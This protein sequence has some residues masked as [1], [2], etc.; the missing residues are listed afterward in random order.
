MSSSITVGWHEFPPLAYLSDKGEIQ[1]YF[2]E[3][4]NEVAEI[5]WNNES[6]VYTSKYMTVDDLEFSEHKET[7][8]L[9]YPSIPDS[10]LSEVYFPPSV[11]R[12]LPVTESFGSFLIFKEKWR[13]FNTNIGLVMSYWKFL[14]LLMSAT[15]WAGLFM[16]ILERKKNSE[17]FPLD[18][19]RGVFEGFWW[20]FVAMS[21]VGFGDKYPKGIVVFTANITLELN[22][23]GIRYTHDILY[24]TVAVMTGS[25][26]VGITLAKG[27]RPREFNTL[28]EIFESVEKEETNYALVGHYPAVH[29]LERNLNE[30]SSIRIV[31]SFPHRQ[32]YGIKV[33][34]KLDRC[35]LRN[36]ARRRRKFSSAIR[37]ITVAY[38]E[39][40]LL[41]EDFSVSQY[42]TVS[43]QAL[44]YSTSSWLLIV[45]TIESGKVQ[46]YFV[47]LIDEIAKTCWKNKSVIYSSKYSSIKDMRL[48]VGRD[49][50]L[51][52]YPFLSKSRIPVAG[53]DSY[54]I[55]SIPVIES[56]GGFLFKK[57]HTNFFNENIILI[58]S[59]WK[60]ILLLGSATAWI[61]LLMWFM[62]RRINKEQFPKDALVGI[63]EGI[64]WAFV[65]MST[66]G[67]GDRY[68]KR[69]VSKVVTLFWILISLIM[70]S[71]FTANI[72]FEL[73]FDGALNAP[74]LLF[75]RVSVV[76]DMEE[77]RVCLS[78]G[79]VPIEYNTTEEVL[80]SVSSEKVSY[81]L[82]GQYPAVYILN[83][84]L[85]D[86]TIG[87]V[88]NYEY[89]EI[90]GLKVM[91][92]PDKCLL[93][94]IASRKK[95]YSL[96]NNISEK[97]LTVR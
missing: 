93:E 92:R 68:P 40:T 58:L 82:I 74:T 72:T 12:F 23:E 51:L 48:S 34:K 73:N 36:I 89:D 60:F 37:N 47:E 25:S 26:D 86:K 53:Y 61:G 31:E 7:I 85:K 14:I 80:Q 33:T 66:V 46:G 57:E 3:L 32:I 95:K 18:T 79:G 42:G 49:N 39:S 28:K 84:G 10:A 19:F 35:F 44:V 90:F 94:T 21:T 83:K 67:Y 11:G 91:G 87:I 16:W 41:N 70:M 50:I 63:F 88:D 76:Q 24:K 96:F 8:L 17:F 13:F 81:G 97:Y 59:Y 65:T 77:R 29:A 69:I 75:K 27:G 45:T 52:P 30:K 1:G 5:C 64:W 38:I 15:T 22:L 71:V 54:D 43:W 56:N 6:I 4:I 62:E 2:I 9:P 78:K 20:A 55:Y